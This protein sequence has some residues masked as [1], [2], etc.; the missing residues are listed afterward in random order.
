MGVLFGSLGASVIVSEV[1]CKNSSAEVLLELAPV[2]GENE[3][4]G[5]GED[6]LA[7]SEEV[8]SCERGM[9]RGGKGEPEAGIEVDEGDDIPFCAVDMLLEGI[10]SHHMPWISGNQSI[11]LPQGFCASEGFNPSCAGDAERDH[12]ETTEVFNETTDG[13]DAGSLGFVLFT[14]LL[15]EREELLLAEV[16]MVIAETSHFFENRRIPDAPALGLRCTASG[17]ECLQLAMTSFKSPLPVEKRTA[18]NSVCLHD[19]IKT[20]FLPER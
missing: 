11:R 2:V 4:E 20:V 6:R 9:R 7:Q 12:P 10:K 8:S 13:T 15:Y 1:K 17:V 5:K 18:F 3:G 19:C 16:W 14:E